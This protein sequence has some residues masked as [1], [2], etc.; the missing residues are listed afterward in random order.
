MKNFESQHEDDIT[1]QNHS[2]TTIVH[3]LQDVKIVIILDAQ[4]LFE[5][6]LCQSMSVFSFDENL[7]PPIGNR[8]KSLGIKSDECDG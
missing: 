3:V 5:N 7:C 4:L 6:H 1:C 8:K 2:D